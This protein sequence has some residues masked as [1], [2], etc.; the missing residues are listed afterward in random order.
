MRRGL[1][2]WD[3]GIMGGCDQ[4]VRLMGA[5]RVTLLFH[6]TSKRQDAQPLQS[7]I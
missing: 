3:Q 2:V 1:L 5:G 6:K 4:G 7:L